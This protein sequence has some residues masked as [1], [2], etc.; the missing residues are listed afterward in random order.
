MPFKTHP[1]IR[2]RHTATIVNNLHQLL[3][4]IF[5]NQFN[6]SSTGIQCILHQFLHSRGRALNDFTCS[7]LVGNG[8]R[9][10]MDDVGHANYGYLGS[11]ISDLYCRWT[12]EADKN[13]LYVYKDIK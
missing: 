3:A 6:R 4:C 8:I 9:Q 5:H 13:L 2:F 7:N 12:N 10:L 11:R 1:R